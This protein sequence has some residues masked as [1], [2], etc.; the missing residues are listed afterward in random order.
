[1][2]KLIKYFLI[3][4]LFFL[5]LFGVFGPKDPAASKKEIEQVTP[6]ELVKLVEEGKNIEDMKLIKRQTGELTLET[7]KTIYRTMVDPDDQAINKLYTD[8][9]LHYQYI[10]VQQ[11]GGFSSLVSS[12]FMI[13]IVLAV[14]GF[15]LN[16]KNETRGAVETG[17]K[18]KEK[19]EIPSVSFSEIG[20]L[21]MDTKKE[22]EQQIRIF[23]QAHE[24]KQLGITTAN[25]ILLYGPPGTGKTLI[26]KAI[27]HELG[28]TF[29]SRS[30]ADFMEMYVG[31]GASRI[32]KLFAEARKNKPSLIFIDEIDAVAGKRGKGSQNEERESTLNQLLIELDGME[33]NDE[34]FVIVATNRMDMLDEAF[35]RSGRFDQ[36]TYIGLP[37]VEGRK[38]IIE[39]HSKQKPLAE[40][41]R[42]S[43]QVIA[44]TTYRYSGA[45]IET[46]FK[47]AANYALM[48]ERKE[49]TMADI[50]YAMDRML[51][52]N[53]GR[54]IANQE[55]KERVAYHEAGH[56][57]ITSLL[58]KG[59]IRKA[60]IV[61][62]GQALGYVAQIP[63][64]SELSTRSTL[65]EQIK[66]TLA[67]GVAE[68][69]K[70]GEHSVGV[71]GDIQQ[72]KN[73]I[74][75][76]TD[77]GMRDVAFELTFEEKEKKE[78]MKMIYQEALEDC[79]RM[80]KV[81]EQK[82][83][84]IAQLL[85][86]KETVEGHEIDAIVHNSGQ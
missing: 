43:L 81:G 80:M 70:Y 42:A 41:V 62:R 10:P 48:A 1:M 83:E 77:I 46:L 33:S 64:E 86:Q 36:K 26:A 5:L 78:A 35:L 3:L 56:A 29:Y 55:T 47:T 85:L 6:H 20:G 44:E 66:I 76:M 68:I 65:M 37:D 73:I 32:R 61:P 67:G 13:F 7:K 28:A 50:D 14:I 38:E 8:H 84:K 69:L 75:H 58:R 25:N 12:I 9:P 74:E 24:A 21:T 72:A 49:I 34:V 31:V 27:A 82:L 63:D 19:E 11:S 60:T 71:G 15:F 2:R 4:N 79:K 18:Q 30:G 39:I 59:N 17:A 16:R 53:E 45:D 51:L 57:L 54:N 23:K 22:I 40:E 52:G